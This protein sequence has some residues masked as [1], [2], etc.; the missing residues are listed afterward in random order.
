[1]SDLK[2]TLSEA[3]QAAFA[4]L[5]LP[6]ELGRVTASDRPDLADF[7][8]NGAL[9]AAKRVGKNPRE[10][11]TAVAEELKSDP[12]SDVAGKDL[13]T[14][15]RGKD[16]LLVYVESYGRVAVDDPQLW[17]VPDVGEQEGRRKRQRAQHRDGPSPIVARE[18]N[19][20][21]KPD[22]SHHPQ[23]WKRTG[24]G[25]EHRHAPRG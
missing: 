5:D 10:L 22:H 6:V 17:R 7:Q 16:V 23:L 3:V 18:E 24:Q 12:L 4:G 9:A 15:L 21:D 1:M 20:S 14:A 13:L 11:A 25:S 2:R 8:S 19:D